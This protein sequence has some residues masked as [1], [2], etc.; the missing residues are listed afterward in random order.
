MTALPHGRTEANRMAYAN[1]IPLKR[2][3]KLTD[4][5]KQQLE[6]SQNNSSHRSVKYE[7]LQILVHKYEPSQTYLNTL[8]R[9]AFPTMNSISH[10]FK[11]ETSKIVN[12]YVNSGIY[13]LIWLLAILIIWVK[14]V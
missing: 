14:L 5:K 8:I 2:L 13:D 6:D 7:Y 12:V 10:V 11:I 3:H 1:H 4:N 9:I